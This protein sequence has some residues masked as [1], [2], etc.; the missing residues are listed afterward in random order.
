MMRTGRPAWI[1]TAA[2]TLPSS[3]DCKRVRP[4]APSTIAMASSS[5]AESQ[6]A[7]HAFPCATRPCARNPA[8]RA[9]STPRPTCRCATSS[10][11]SSNCKALESSLPI[12]ASRIVAGSDGDQS[13]IGSLTVMTTAGRGPSSRPAVAMAFAA[14]SEPSKHR[15]TGLLVAAS[16][17]YSRINRLNHRLSAWASAVCPRL[18]CGPIP[19]RSRRPRSKLEG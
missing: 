9:N 3:A 7:R 12:G 4:R 5:S 16:V 11:I 10:A 17:G 6:I 2:E 15:S 13:L 14:S 8:A 18:P 1:E 19:M